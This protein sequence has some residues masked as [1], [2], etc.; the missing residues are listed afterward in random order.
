MATSCFTGCMSGFNAGLLLLL[1]RMEGRRMNVVFLVTVVSVC[2]P[3]RT[4]P[5]YENNT[6]PNMKNK[7]TALFDSLDDSSRCIYHFHRARTL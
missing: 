5:K 7:L 1:P 2:S 6:V 3:I 4:S